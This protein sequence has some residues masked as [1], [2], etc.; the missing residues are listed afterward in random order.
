MNGEFPKRLRKKHSGRQIGEFVARRFPLGEII[1]MLG[2]PQIM[3]PTLLLRD[4]ANMKSA[5]REKVVNN[6]LILM[7]NSTDVMQEMQTTGRG[8]I[9]P[10][11]YLWMVLTP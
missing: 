11:R 1:N 4:N 9:I 7:A 6:C 2:Q 5:L 10:E 3:P 8:S